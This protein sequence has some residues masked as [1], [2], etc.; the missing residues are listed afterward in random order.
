MKFL[1]LI[2]CALGCS[3]FSHAKIIDRIVAVVNDDIISQSDLD[4]YQKR[5]KASSAETITHSP[6]KMLELLIEEILL[7]Q[8]VKKLNLSAEEEEVTAHINTILKNQGITQKDLL[9]FLKSRGLTYQQYKENIK[10]GLEQQRLLEREIQSSIVIKKEDIRAYYYNSIKNKSSKKKYHI[11]QIFFPIESADQA[12]RILKKA[13][14]VHASYQKGIPF[15]NLLQENSQIQ[16]SSDDL[17]LLSDEDMAPSFK[18]AIKNLPLK[19]LSSPFKTRGGIHLIEILEIRAQSA[20]NFEDVKDDIQKILS[21]KEFKKALNQ[22]LKA[23]KAEAH[24]KILVH[25][26]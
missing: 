1:F 4:A 15:E 23:K 25:V 18:K 17:G 12:D 8:L 24:I 10:Q 14:A 2:L 7:K 26:K 16:G 19:K 3:P 21:E 5:V 22:W 9:S 13:R 6:K 20:Q 11:R